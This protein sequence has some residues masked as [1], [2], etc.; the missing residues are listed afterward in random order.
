MPQWGRPPG[1]HLGRPTRRRGDPWLGGETGTGVLDS[2]AED[3]HGLRNDRLFTRQSAGHYAP[4]AVDGADYDMYEDTDSTVAYAVRL[5]MKDN[6]EWLVEKALERIRR[7]HSEGQMNVRLSKR[8]LQAL[9]RKRLQDESDIAI[10]TRHLEGTGDG[11]TWRNATSAAPPPPYPRDTSVHATWS[12][13]TSAS[14]SPQSSTTALR[15]ALQPPFSSSLNHSAAFLAPPAASRP[16]PEDSQWMASHQT[17]RAR[18][19]DPRLH[20][21]VDPLRGSRARTRQPPYTN[22]PT[23]APFVSPDPA[24]LSS[25]QALN[26]DGESDRGSHKQNSSGKRSPTSNGDEV[27]MVEV[28]EHKVPNSPVGAANIGIRQRNSRS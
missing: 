14:V 5:A 20:S 18:G 9:E 27:H 2:E 25:E 12:R 11:M 8:E 23:Q 16:S 19:P 3:Q 1:A 22:V 10:D 6:E 13:I 4:E 24:A 15:S 28:I 26:R 7:A 21:P 17:S